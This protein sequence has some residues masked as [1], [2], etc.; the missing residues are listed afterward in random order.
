MKNDVLTNSI[1]HD[2]VN[3]VDSM[4]L[5]SNVENNLNEML[6]KYSH[7]KLS[8]EE[9]AEFRNELLENDIE[10]NNESDEVKRIVDEQMESAQMKAMSVVYFSHFFLYFFK[11]FII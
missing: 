10:E 1:I 3:I 2:M 9:N 6:H 7:Q 5:L 11:K 4:P 8:M